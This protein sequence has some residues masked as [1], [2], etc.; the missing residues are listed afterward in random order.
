MCCKTH[1]PPLFSGWSRSRAWVEHLP[2]SRVGTGAGGRRDPVGQPGAAAA[3]RARGR[4]GSAPCWRGA[5]VTRRGAGTRVGGVSRSRG[6]FTAPGV[7]EAR[8][9]TGG[10]SGSVGGHV[11][12]GTAA[13]CGGAWCLEA[14]GR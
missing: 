9:C 5:E 3:T 14:G 12:G 11:L 1:T 13:G 8:V 10:C 2:R 4:A 6:G 7:E